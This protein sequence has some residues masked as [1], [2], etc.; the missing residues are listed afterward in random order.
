MSFYEKNVTIS[1]IV[2]NSDQLRI[3]NISGKMN[4]PTPISIK[5]YFNYF[6]DSTCNSY[7]L[8]VISRVV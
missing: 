3:I 2:T 8:S 6:K 4:L 7:L 1:E 5:Q